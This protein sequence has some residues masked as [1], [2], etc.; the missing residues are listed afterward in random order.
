[1]CQALLWV[2]ELNKRNEIPAFKK[3]KTLSQR[4]LEVSTTLFIPCSQVPGGRMR[5]LTSVVHFLCA[6]V[7][8]SILY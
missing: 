2:L 1:M 6:L 5:W 4:H 7:S 3:V 8:I